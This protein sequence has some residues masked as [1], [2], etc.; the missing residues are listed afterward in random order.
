MMMKEISLH[1]LDIIQNSLAAGATLIEIELCVRHAEDRM[2]LSISDNGCGM[3][4]EFQRQV[5]DPFVTTRTT[6]KVGLGIPMFMAGAQAAGGTF[7]MQS[8]PGEGTRIEASY[9]IS[10]WDRPPLGNIAETLYASILCNEMVD[11]VFAYT[12][13]DKSFRLD[14]R[15]IKAVLEGAPLNAPAVSAWLREYLFEGIEALNGGV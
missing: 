6:R 15:E 12:V 14:T 4:P 3:T 7:C 9:Q 13:D 8:A 2:T 5:L 10:H 1:V 11:F